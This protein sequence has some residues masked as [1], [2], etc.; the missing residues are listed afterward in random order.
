MHKV[1]SENCCNWRVSLGESPK[2][3]LSLPAAYAKQIGLCMRRRTDETKPNQTKPY[4]TIRNVARGCKELHTKA[5]KAGADM[6]ETLAGAVDRNRGR[7]I[8]YHQL[9]SEVEAK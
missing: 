5:A 1:K 6:M 7:R 4:R 9:G 2:I 8:H 3:P